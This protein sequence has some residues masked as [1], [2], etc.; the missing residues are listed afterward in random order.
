MHFSRTQGRSSWRYDKWRYNG[1]RPP[2]S[3]THLSSISRVGVDRSALRLVT[4]LTTKTCAACAVA[5]RREPIMK[6]VNKPGV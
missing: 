4:P 3:L 5:V 2:P 1:A 6:D